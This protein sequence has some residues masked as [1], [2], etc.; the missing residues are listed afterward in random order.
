MGLDLVCFQ[1]HLRVEHDKLFLHALPVRTQEV[2][3]AEVDLERV[4]V[5]IVLLLPVVVAA[6]ADVAALVLV[7]AVCV[8]FIVSVEAHLAEAAL[9]MSFEAALVDGTGVVV[10][11][12]LVPSEIGRSEEGVLV[13]EDLLVPCTEVAGIYQRSRSAHQIMLPTT[14]TFRAP[15]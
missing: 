10:A 11:E 6:V 2:V 14:W 3:L 15:S 5:D 13:G 9:G 8:E 4:V 12:F 7:S 1:V